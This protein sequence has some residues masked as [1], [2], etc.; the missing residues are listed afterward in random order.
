MTKL[1]TSAT[2][3][4]S[5]LAAISP[6]RVSGQDARRSRY[7]ASRDYAK[8]EKEVAAH[9]AADRQKSRLVPGRELT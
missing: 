8:F 3:A 7:A 2:L 1:I 9:A 4:L 6:A 5:L